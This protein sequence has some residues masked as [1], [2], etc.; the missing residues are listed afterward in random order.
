MLGSDIGELVFV[1][2]LLLGAFAVMAWKGYSQALVM[3]LVACVLLIA[4]ASDAREIVEHAFKEFGPIALLF[5]AVAIPASQ[6][7]RSMFFVKVGASLGAFMGRTQLRRESLLIPLLVTLVLFGTYVAAGLFHNITAIFVMVP[8]AI[9]ICESY[10]VPSRWLLCGQLVASNLGGFSTRWGDTPN[11]LE[12]REWG[13][14]HADFY[15]EIL[16]ANVV[17][18]I[19]LCA[20]VAF[21]TAKASQAAPTTTRP[22]STA[23]RAAVFTEEGVNTRLDTRLFII[24]AGVLTAF[25]A[26]QLLF[27]AWDLATAAA[28]ILASVLLERPANRMEALHA[29]GLEVYATLA[30][31]FMIAE[32]IRHTSLG[33]LLRQLIEGADGAPWAIVLASYIGTGLTEAASWA[34]ATAPMV[35]AVNA[36]HSAAWALGGGICAGSS[37]VLTAASAGIIL[38]TQSRAVP[39]H[40]VSFGRYLVFGVTASIC[41]AAFYIAYTTVLAAIGH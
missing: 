32:S 30:A 26:F 34:A 22:A 18:M 10:G 15:T 7:K 23:F 40:E 16:P 9:A 36:D 19:A 12:A 31:V 8:I 20:A 35:H 4:N 25:I 17:V 39:G 37:S 41:M 21:F 6:I 5:T 24:G 28:A 29:L 11:I 33:E 13:L 3:P 38:W 1:I 27:P 2:A 14:S